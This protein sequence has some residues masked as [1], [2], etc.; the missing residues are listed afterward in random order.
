MNTGYKEKR[1]HISKKLLPKPVSGNGLI[2]SLIDNLPV[3]LHLP[4]Y[5]YAGPGTNLDLRLEK[6]IKPKNLLDEAAM[7]HDIAYSKSNNLEDRHAA[8]KILQE[9]AWNRVLAPDA[10]IGEKSMGWLVTNA[11]KAKRALGAG[12]K[13]HS[14]NLEEFDKSSII[15]ASKPVEVTVNLVRTK[16]SLMND[17]SLPL[18]N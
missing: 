2:N 10:G 7:Y 11:M 3:E 16:E 6:G 12:L 15:S 1:I 17:I 5:N 13:P 14:V 9:A 18:T 4:G 8:D